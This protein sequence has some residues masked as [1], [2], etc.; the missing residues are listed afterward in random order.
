MYTIATL[1]LSNNPRINQGFDPETI[2]GVSW[3]LVEQSFNI[4]TRILKLDVQFTA[5]NFTQQR[6]FTYQIP[7]EVET[8]GVPQMIGLLLSET[9]LQ[10]STSQ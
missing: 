10:N 7:P 6:Q 2:T 9:E 1:N 3:Q 4:Q 8:M 5:S